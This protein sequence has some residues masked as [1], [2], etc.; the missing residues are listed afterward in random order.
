M[1]VFSASGVKVATLDRRSM[2]SNVLVSL[3]LPILTRL[4]A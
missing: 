1:L 2:R 4:L 3:T